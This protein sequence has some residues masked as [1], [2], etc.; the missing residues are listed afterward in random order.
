MAGIMENQRTVEFGSD[1][2]LMLFK[3]NVGFIKK[4]VLENILVR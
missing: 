1:K 2:L 4:H 3:K